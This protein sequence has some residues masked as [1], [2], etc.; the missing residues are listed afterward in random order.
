MTFSANIFRNATDTAEY[1]AGQ[2]IFVE[3]AEGTVAYA[4][5]DGQ[6]DLIANGSLLE[7]LGPGDIFGEMA[8]IEK[9]RSATAKAR[10]RCR[11]APIDTPGFERLVQQDPGFATQVLC[12]MAERLRRMNERL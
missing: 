2:S 3:G 4:I 12:S 7:T 10:K 9:P 5:I 1:E 11:L 6:V 8:I